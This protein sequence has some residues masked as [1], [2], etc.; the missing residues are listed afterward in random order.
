MPEWWAEAAERTA[1]GT[2]GRTAVGTA[3]EIRPEAGWPSE[4]VFPSLLYR[5]TNELEPELREVWFGG[6]VWRQMMALALGESDPGF[7]FRLILD[8]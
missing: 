4:V 8:M 2:A 1:V 5:I 6:G 7:D 3:D